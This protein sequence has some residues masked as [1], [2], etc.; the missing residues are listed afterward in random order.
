MP[1]PTYTPLAKFTVS[2]NTT[3][4]NITNINQNYLDLVLV[5]DLFTDSG[6]DMEIRYNGD[7]STNYALQSVGNNQGSREARYQNLGFYRIPSGGTS[8]V[9][10]TMQIKDYAKTN[11][12][13]C[14]ILTY[15]NATESFLVNTQYFSTNA[16]TSI[17]INRQQ[18]VLIVP[19]TTVSLY[20]IVG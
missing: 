9:S 7:G 20:G 16:I 17:S 1:T 8:G 14:A 4:I 13:K 6:G 19:G 10:V 5:Y 11:K 12:V 15:T 2:S 18:S 3:Q